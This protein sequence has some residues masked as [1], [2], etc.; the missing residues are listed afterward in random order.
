MKEY[1][2]LTTEQKVERWRKLLDVGAQ[3]FVMK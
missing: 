1:K 2:N 3:V